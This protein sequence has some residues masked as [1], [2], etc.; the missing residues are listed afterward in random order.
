MYEGADL[1]ICLLLPRGVGLILP[2]VNYVL[3]SVHVAQLSTCTLS[4]YSIKY[5]VY[6]ALLMD[7][8]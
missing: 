2:W 6:W 5:P 3:V 8:I 1:D 7:V 4:L